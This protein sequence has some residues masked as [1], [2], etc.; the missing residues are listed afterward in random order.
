MNA[1]K[2]GV[3]NSLLR[4]QLLYLLEGRGA[5]ISFQAAV[6]GFPVNLL[7]KRIPLLAHTAWQLVDHIRVVQWDIL[8]F[9][10]NPEPV[11]LG[12]N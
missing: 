6:K 10:L 3:Q 4:E 2:S 9:I 12:E 8:E 5:H 1:E 11:I 7:G